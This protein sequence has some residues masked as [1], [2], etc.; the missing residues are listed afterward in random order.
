[1]SEINLDT[2]IVEDANE[3]AKQQIAQICP[4]VPPKGKIFD[5]VHC[6]D[7]GDP[8]DTTRLALVATCRCTECKGYHQ[9][10]LRS[11]SMQKV[12]EDY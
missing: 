10:E 7:C 9:K 3:M 1:M 8:L 2:V 4:D 6:I 5:G 12:T 11:Q